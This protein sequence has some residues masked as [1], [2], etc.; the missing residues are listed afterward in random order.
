MGLLRLHPIR[1]WGRGALRP[2]QVSAARSCLVWPL[3]PYA[4]LSGLVARCRIWPEV[5]SKLGRSSS[6]L[7]I[8]NFRLWHPSASLLWCRIARQDARLVY[9]QPGPRL[10]ATG[11]PRPGHASNVA[12]RAAVE[13]EVPQSEIAEP[14]QRVRFDS[15]APLTGYGHP[16]SG[17]GRNKMDTVPN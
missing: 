4:R 17:Y 8:R 1:G 14:R 3:L 10:L 7:A 16:G 9:R 13:P 11:L 2:A 6:Q 15:S 5:L 12:D